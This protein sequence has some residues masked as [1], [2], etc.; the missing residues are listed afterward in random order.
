MRVG[1]VMEK[2]KGLRKM[3]TPLR[4]FEKLSTL[5]PSQVA[6]LE[7]YRSRSNNPAQI[8]YISNMLNTKKHIPDPI[9]DHP[10]HR[11]TILPV[12]HYDGTGSRNIFQVIG[13][14]FVWLFYILF[15]RSA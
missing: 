2:R 13:D 3:N 12:A 7:E 9:F 4:F 6:Y 10:R 8:E 5:T 1:G 14:F 11:Q 15:R